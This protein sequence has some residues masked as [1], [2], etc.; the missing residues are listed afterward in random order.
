MSNAFLSSDEFRKS[1]TNDEGIRRGD[2]F[3]VAA[4]KEGGD[5]ALQVSLVGLGEWIEMPAR[6]IESAKP[7]GTAIAQADRDTV[8]LIKLREPDDV[9]AKAAYQ[10]LAQVGSVGHRSEDRGECGCKTA[11]H[12]HEE[13]ESEQAM[14]TRSGARPGAVTGLGVDPGFFGGFGI[15][16]KCRWEVRCYDCTRCIPWTNVCWKSTCCDLVKVDCEVSI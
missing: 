15:G 7:V 8:A 10:M 4:V 14:L 2:G 9:F 6:M 5:Q 3:I 13:R 12:D 16:G 11:G 1:M